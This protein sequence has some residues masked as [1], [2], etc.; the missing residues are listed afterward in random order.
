MNAV[1]QQVELPRAELLRFSALD[2]IFYGN[3]FFPKTI[4][5]SSPEFHK[6]FW[7]GFENPN[8]DFFAAE[9]FRGGAKTTL[10]RIGLS[11]RIAFGISRNI[12]TVAIAENMAMHTVRWIKKQIEQNRLWTETFMLRKGSKWSDEWIEIVNE[13]CECA[14]NV[15]AKG[16]TSGLRGL[17]LD[18]FR[19]DFIQCDDIESD[20]TV[21]TEDQR[22]KAQDQF[23]GALVPSLAPRSEAPHR[24]LAFLQTNLHKESLLSRA[25]K[26]PTFY[27]VRYPKLI[28]QPDG[29]LKSAWES[30]FPTEEAIREKED[31]VRRGQ[32]HVWLREFGCKIVSRETA[33]LDATQLRYYKALPTTLSYYVGLDPASAGS[34]KKYAHKTA[35][36]C[37]GVD[38]RTGD[39]YLISYNAQ[40]GKN[41]DEMWTW[42]LS[43]YRTFRPRKIGTETVGFQK[44]LEWYF[45]TKMQET[46]IFFPI[47][48]FNDRRSKPNRIIQAYTGLASQG[49]LWVHENH[50]EFVTAYTEWVEGQDNDLLDAGAQAIT[51]ANP[52]MM[53]SD[54]ED[55][56]IGG[57]EDD[58]EELS[59][60]EES[61]AP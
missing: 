38:E 45:K 11:K 58:I 3:H 6:D 10:T 47:F 27:Y 36:V 49:K 50:T 59:F 54:N 12:L 23:F 30:R 55:D 35:T 8:Y 61:S 46:R 37:I 34:D 21:G 7:Y 2:S 19:P 4:R 22:N 43:A 56:I 24:K 57:G 14:I 33:P 31:Y 42:V 5:Q 40:K 32:L 29:T 1:V 41:P 53:I 16:M 52:W 39:V 18:D 44:V 25:S 26:D 48:P 20:E 17:N 51:L 9:I 60:D 13:S 15:I 28:E